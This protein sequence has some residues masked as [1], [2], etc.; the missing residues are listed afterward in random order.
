MSYIGT[1]KEGVIVLP[2]DVKLREG[3]QVR[4]EPVAAGSEAPTLG[5]RLLRFAGTAQGLPAD[6]ARNHDHYL[7]GRAKQ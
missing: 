5:Q 1:V 2:P 6:M 4:V 3:S 7:H